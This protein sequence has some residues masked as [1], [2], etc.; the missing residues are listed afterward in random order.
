MK[1]L[2][3]GE[4][5]L[6]GLAGVFV[7][8]ALI[9]GC[10]TYRLEGVVVEGRAPAVMVVDADDDRL[11]QPGIDGVRVEAVLDPSSL[12]PRLLTRQTTGLSG[13]FTIQVDETGAGM[14]EYG[15]YVL[16]RGEGFRHTEHT[17]SLPRTNKRLLIVMMP[18]RDT[19][20]PKENLLDEFG[21]AKRQFD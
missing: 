10:S 15:L 20:K 1:R 16:A 3:G 17:L 8:S 9:G 19:Y 6:L 4:Q 18:G 11:K 5:R 12:R 2:S 21:R 7:V 14:L 13:R